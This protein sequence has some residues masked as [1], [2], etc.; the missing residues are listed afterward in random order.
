MVGDAREQGLHREPEP[1]AYWV[2]SAPNPTPLFVLRTSGEPMAA[3]GARSYHEPA[4][5]RSGVRSPP[6][7]TLVSD[8]PRTSGGETCVQLGDAGSRP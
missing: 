3:A 2:D 6:T 1:T 7:P 4:S 5:F 8:E